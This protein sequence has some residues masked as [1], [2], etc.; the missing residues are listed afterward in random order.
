M[1]CLK[2]NT[3]LITLLGGYITT[4]L[5]DKSKSDKSFSVDEVV[6]QVYDNF[7]KM[8]ASEELSMDAARMA[9]F[10][11]LKVAVLAPD[12]TAN[13]E[14]VNPDILY[15]ILD[16]RKKTLNDDSNFTALK[17]ILGIGV[18]D[19][20][21]LD[22]LEDAVKKAKTP[23]VVETIAGKIS[24]IFNGFKTY[25]QVL[26]NFENRNA[27]DYLIP[28]RE[29]VRSSA[30][31][32]NID[33]LLNTQ[34]TYNDISNS[35]Q[36]VLPGLSKPGVYLRSMP[37]KKAL[38]LYP[39]AFKDYRSNFYPDFVNILVDSDGNAINFDDN[40]NVNQT[41]GHPVFYAIED[42]PLRL[43]GA[44]VI[45]DEQYKEWVEE[46]KKT[47]EYT[48][49]ET[50]KAKTGKLYVKSQIFKQ[51]KQRIKDIE[52]SKYPADTKLMTNELMDQ[53][54]DEAVQ[55]VIVFYNN[56]DTF[57]NHLNN[58][59]DDVIDN[60]FVKSGKGFIT[61]NI[62]AP[63]KLSSIALP[64][65]QKVNIDVVTAEQTLGS[66]LVP[67]N[68]YIKVPGIDEKIT[69]LRKAVYENPEIAESINSFFT[70][71][72]YIRQGKNVIPM[73]LS[74][75][76]T[77]I[78]QFMM[79]DYS[80]ITFLYTKD[81]N[82]GDPNYAFEK[83]DGTK[84]YKLKVANYPS[85]DIKFDNSPE[86]VAARKQASDYIKTYFNSGFV[87]YDKTT[88]EKSA[89][90]E[91]NQDIRDKNTKAKD[92]LD[93]ARQDGAK[94][95]FG[96]VATADESKSE[97]IAKQV[98]SLEPNTI[99]GYPTGSKVEGKEFEY[100]LVY[101][102]VF[103]IDK[104]LANGKYREVK[105][106]TITPDGTI[107]EFTRDDER[108]EYNDFIMN[109]FSTNA[110][111]NDL[112]N[113]TQVN[114]SF[115]FSPTFESSE[116]I[117]DK[118]TAED[119]AKMEEQVKESV[120]QDPMTGN[121]ASNVKPES[122][123]DLFDDKSFQKSE[124]QRLAE[125]KAT[126]VKSAKGLVWYL[127][128]TKAKNDANFKALYNSLSAAEKKELDKELAEGRTTPHELSK[129][130]PYEVLFRA[131][132]MQGNNPSAEWVV[133][134][135]ILYSY[136]KKSKA[137]A[138]EIDFTNLYHEAWH[139]FTQTF[140][141][142]EERDALYNEASKKDGSFR[143]FNGRYVT[144]QS[145]TK[146]Q[147]DEFMAEDFRTYM[148]NGGRVSDTKAPVKNSIFRRLL[149]FFKQLFGKAS[150]DQVAFDPRNFPK[151]N[152]IYQKIS[153]GDFSSYN[154][155]TQNIDQTMGTFERSMLATDPNAKITEIG[156][157]DANK[158]YTT[159]SSMISTYA[160]ELNKYFTERK[161][162]EITSYSTQLMKE[163]Q[164][165][166]KV[167]RDIKIKFEN[168]LLPSL[169]KRI[170]GDVAE[171][172][173]M[174]LK[175]EDI[176]ANQTQLDSLA[177]AVKLDT[178]K[179]RTISAV[180]VSSILNL[181]PD[182]VADVLKRINAELATIDNAYN[183]QQLIQ[184]RDL[185]SWSID[186]FGDT[187]DLSKNTDK[188]V[189]AYHLK[190]SKYEITKT[191]DEEVEEVN[192]AVQAEKGKNEYDDL[193]NK[194]SQFDIAKADIHY[195]LG[196]I[197]KYDENN[198]PV[199]NDLGVQI[200]EDK[201]VVWNRVSRLLNGEID[202]EEM[203][204]ILHKAA[205]FG[206]KNDLI[207]KQVLQK[208]GSISP[209]MTEA[210]ARTWI[211]FTN[212]FSMYNNPLY[213]MNIEYKGDD[214]FKVAVGSV[215]SIQRKVRQ[216]WDNKFR[217][218]E[219]KHFKRNFDIEADPEHYRKTYLDVASLLS[220]R[221]LGNGTSLMDGAAFE[222]F[223]SIG[224][225][226]S[227]KPEVKRAVTRPDNPVGSAPIIYG[228]L[229]DMFA[230]GVTRI[231]SL[232]EIFDEFPA[233]K[234]FKDS[235]PSQDT[236][237][238]ELANLE[239]K[240]SDYTSNYLESNAAGNPQFSLTQHSSLSVMVTLL[241]KGKSLR[242]LLTDYPF[243]QK[244]N[245]LTQPAAAVSMELNSMFD[246]Q[247]F[248]NGG[249]G[250]RR[251]RNGVPVQYKT[252]NVAGLRYIDDEMGD[253]GVETS[254]LDPYSKLVFDFH[255]LA[256]LNRMEFMTPADKST[257]LSSYLTYIE[258]GSQ[259]GK[260]YIEPISAYENESGYVA[261][262]GRA[263]EIF[264]RYL[265]GE[266]GRIAKM[267][268]LQKRISELADGEYIVYDAA[269]LKQGQEFIVFEDIISK[270]LL[271]QI[272]GYKTIEEASVALNKPDLKNEIEQEI[273]EYLVDQVDQVSNV[274]NEAPFISEDLIQQTNARAKKYGFS[275]TKNKTTESL[276][277]SYVLNNWINN[278]ESSI[279]IFGD[280]AMYKLKSEEYHKR[281]AGAQSA[282][283]IPVTNKT[284]IEYVNNKTTS[285]KD[286][287]GNTIVG[288]YAMSLNDPTIKEKPLDLNGRVDVA[289]LEDSVVD[290][291]K[292][293]EIM[294]GLLDNEIEINAYKLKKLF[295]KEQEKAFIKELEDRVL[296]DIG[297]YKNMKEGDGQGWIAFDF[298]RRVSMLLDIW[299]P[300]QNEMFNKIINKEEFDV[301]NVS[302]FFPVLK[303]QYWGALGVEADMLAVNGYHKFSLFPLIPPVIE[304]TP[305]E[306]IHMK[307][308]RDEIDYAVFKSGSKIGN[309]NKI[310]RSYLPNSDA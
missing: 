249:E 59:P 203:Y 101:R 220:D 89:S 244:Y 51:V 176:K 161:G 116:K 179:N 15:N 24:N 109:N 135:I 292:I 169:N 206:G 54:Y 284:I 163:S 234:D 95:V 231:Y 121:N 303:L 296:A 156:Y 210:S 177:E 140:L 57:L 94:F 282:K 178:N 120:K 162:K 198:K 300:I 18:V 164:F 80:T 133:K 222:F 258:G 71:L 293:G 41:Q 237:F 204:N 73:S 171:F 26:I 192:D 153:I 199:L 268:E 69:I 208:L 291:E 157:E 218:A 2:D 190:K 277:R 126:R 262:Y 70:D 165:A 232:N 221:R 10:L 75:R 305:L 274:F 72:L 290:S 155:N 266:M 306:D 307:M 111:V 197:H 170:E 17:G 46:F 261:A 224:V 79:M 143:D 242:Q 214:K 6:K 23:S 263:A 42:K 141:T 227:D 68:A 260:Y 264:S 251:V 62:Y 85:I 50:D 229:R 172:I 55:D 66:S 175:K 209:D 304:G 21:E 28:K 36:L 114:P 130:F 99:F 235:L 137:E 298:Y 281:N 180:S 32:K 219:G 259:N 286:D 195:L 166:L 139:G 84:F 265:D 67:G 1:S 44:L 64:Q 246:V 38:E 154:F 279:M 20:S 5:I 185:I 278:Y 115:I 236:N 152:E 108:P 217:T 184:Q 22:A 191:V 33:T 148:M 136:Y 58:N 255:S 285:Q 294:Q 240:N 91:F 302:Q 105:S 241:N 271:D 39:M 216:I 47:P 127:G 147:L 223:N 13:L 196:N 88:P 200:L 275:P 248:I 243:M 112:G 182:K 254:K 43:K 297:T 269:Y 267:Q 96:H 211:S 3:R 102:P 230:R 138:S 74:D 168:E 132:N 188:G 117:N 287:N 77:Y 272:K 34:I 167:Y 48:E 159:V 16:L 106:K 124:Q 87:I 228:R 250:S 134:G 183:T 151:I 129:L 276:V 193:S 309:L 142:P 123:F 295:S 301:N 125:N 113:I 225:A 256:F 186:N 49:L 29:Y 194:Q 252:G 299:T 215:N 213:Q 78:K 308:M 158:I 253:V 104:E 150:V 288:S 245:P 82:T 61:S 174:A 60:V 205:N 86:D 19:T 35:S 283:T 173:N 98:S 93:K 187:T 56:L 233:T 119:R 37:V 27:P 280:P 81:E 90:Y 247:D 226:L 257:R 110:V 144:F 31:K 8:N 76:I 65:G 160:N 131:V 145:A 310:D 97:S 273:I 201:F 146:K 239:T 53:I 107:I 40:G 202:P 30:V 100:F 207:I 289:V 122:F 45:T 11:M 52:D 63:S 92:V 4:V 212:V 189:I 12:I 128:S 181:S 25:A 103:N 9:P 238:T 270:R 149:N 14:K 118:L 83:A 7:K